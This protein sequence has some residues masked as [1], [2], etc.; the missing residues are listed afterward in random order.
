MGKISYG[1]MASIDG[2][3]ED[4]S[5][6]FDWSTPVE[7]THRM[8]NDQE[9]RTGLHLYGRRLWETMKVWGPMAEDESL[10]EYE[11]EFAR[12]WAKV[13]TIVFSRT[14][15]E[16]PEGVQLRRE[17][18]ADEIRRLKETTEGEISLGGASL[19]AE[20]R[21]H[22]LIDEYQ[23]FAV[24]IVVGQGK[25]MFQGDIIERLELLEVRPLP[26]GVTLLRYAPAAEAV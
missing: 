19:A 7:E 11:L 17:V 15:S 1:F 21:K 16:V 8:F 3:I 14:L 4:A 23:V 6:D 13:P 2:F 22:G 5:G 20:F 26:A 9:A 10:T 12:H 24:P 25:R 18:D